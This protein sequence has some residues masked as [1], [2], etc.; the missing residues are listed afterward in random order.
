[1]RITIGLWPSTL[2]E[3]S[4]VTEVAAG[5]LSIYLLWGWPNLLENWSM[6]VTYWSLINIA[7]P[8]CG[9]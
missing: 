4:P 8:L 1:M 6:I 2:E 5:I 7:S 3:I 9:H